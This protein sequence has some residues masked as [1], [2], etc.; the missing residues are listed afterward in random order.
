MHDAEREYIGPRQGDFKGSDKE[1]FDSYRKAYKKLGNMKVDVKSPN[2]KYILGKDVTPSQ[3]VD[4]I[5]D[6]L[7]KQGLY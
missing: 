6:W 1:L 2:G 4:L 3:A 7:K 5:E